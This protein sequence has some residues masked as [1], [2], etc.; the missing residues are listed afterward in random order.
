MTH[1]HMRLDPFIHAIWLIHMCGMTHS[2][3]RHDSFICVTC[4]IHMYDIPDLYVLH[5]SFIYVT[6]QTHMHYSTHLHAW[7]DLFIR[8]TRILYQ[9]NFFFFY[10]YAYL[11]AHKYA[12]LMISIYNRFDSKL[13]LTVNIFHRWNKYAFWLACNMHVHSSWLAYYKYALQGGIKS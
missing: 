4:L 5:D 11:L 3:V 13:D 9:K 1:S 2:Y 6:W 7:N 8:V 10:K 12:L